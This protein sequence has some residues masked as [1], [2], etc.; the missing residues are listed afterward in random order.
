M[1]QLGG[2]KMPGG[3]VSEAKER[4][5]GTVNTPDDEEIATKIKD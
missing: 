3:A 2:R 1:E 4:C 5:Q